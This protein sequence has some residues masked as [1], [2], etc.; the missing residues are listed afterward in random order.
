MEKRRDLL[1]T[2]RYHLRMFSRAHRNIDA[3]DDE[4]YELDE[5]EDDDDVE[6]GY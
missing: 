6:E 3:D 4:D 1:G 2:W 5:E